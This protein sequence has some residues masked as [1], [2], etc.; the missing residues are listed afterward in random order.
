M[1]NVDLDILTENEEII[2]QI[3][4]DNKKIVIKLDNC[5]KCNYKIYKDDKLKFKGGS[6][7]IEDSMFKISESVSCL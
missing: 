6:A 2:F 7:N 1:R 3:V 4:K 5:Q